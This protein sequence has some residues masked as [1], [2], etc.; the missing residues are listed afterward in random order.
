MVSYFHVIDNLFLKAEF[1]LLKLSA[2]LSLC[3]TLY[4]QFDVAGRA[5][6]M[7]RV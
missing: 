5:L 1:H 2:A 6:I 4:D 3:A 7:Q